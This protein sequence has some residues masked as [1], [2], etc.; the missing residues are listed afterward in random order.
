MGFLDD[1]VE[2]IEL[3][4]TSG[5]TSTAYTTA[6]QTYLNTY[7]DLDELKTLITV[8]SFRNEPFDENFNYPDTSKLRFIKTD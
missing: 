5:I 2:L 4:A 6:K 8:D 3:A 1:T 7:E